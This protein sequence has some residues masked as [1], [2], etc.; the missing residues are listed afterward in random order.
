MALLGSVSG[1]VASTGSFGKVTIGTTGFTG[2]NRDTD[3]KLDVLGGINI[4]GYKK[5]NFDGNGY[6]VHGFIRLNSLNPGGGAVPML[7][8]FAY[9]GHRVQNQAGA[10]VDFGFKNTS[11]RTLFHGDVEVAG[12]LNVDGNITAQ[13]YCKF[14]SY[15]YN[16]SIS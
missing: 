10:I 7:Y 16:L 6:S 15:K 4:E 13:L 11:T 9:Y 2:G 5:I 14:I 1:S 8:S 3:A 12:D